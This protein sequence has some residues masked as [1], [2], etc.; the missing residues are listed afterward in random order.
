MFFSSVSCFTQAR[1]ELYT[2]K[3]KKATKTK[4]RT[5]LT[6]T[7]DISI[8]CADPAVPPRDVIPHWV[9]EDELSAGILASNAETFTGVDYTHRVIVS[10]WTGAAFDVICAWSVGF[11]WVEGAPFVGTGFEGP[12]F[13]L[14]DG[15]SE[16]EEREEGDEDDGRKLHCGGGCGVL[17]GLEKPWSWWLL[18]RMNCAFHLQLQMGGMHVLIDSWR[19]NNGRQ[20]GAARDHVAFLP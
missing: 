15:V 3:K 5:G 19:A 18:C 20:T 12:R 16:G 4:T 13:G 2:A 1:E 8:K 17:D 10:V 9:P 11:A 6:L 14:G 7:T